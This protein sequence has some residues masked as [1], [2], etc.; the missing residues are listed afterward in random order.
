MLDDGFRGY[1]CLGGPLDG[2]PLAMTGPACQYMG[3]L[4][5]F[6]HVYEIDEEAR[7]WRYIGAKIVADVKDSTDE[8]K[9]HG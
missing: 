9:T 8:A 2:M 3:C 4:Y 1:E 6:H 7:V 5:Q